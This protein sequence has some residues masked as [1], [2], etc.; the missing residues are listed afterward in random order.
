MTGY[1]PRRMNEIAA[2]MRIR[3]TGEMQFYHKLFHHLF[4]CSH[5]ESRKPALS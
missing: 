2:G 5:T 3:K 1:N 4:Q